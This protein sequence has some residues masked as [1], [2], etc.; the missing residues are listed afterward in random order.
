M[1]LENLRYLNI[2]L[3]SEDIKKLSCNKFKSI[4]KQKIEE[5]AMNYLSNKRK[6]KTKDID[7]KHFKPKQYLMSNNLSVTEVQNLYKLRNHMIDVKGNFHSGNTD[8]MWC[9]TCNLFTETQ[10]HLVYCPP[11]R[12]KLR[13][14]V[15]FDLMDHSMV[16]QSL[17][18]QEFYAKNYTIIL[19]ARE[20]VLSL[21]NG[22]Q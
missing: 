4:L 16:F 21:I 20:D 19:N 2:K 12:E 10:Q 14:L 9:R 7:I 6:E 13:G 17:K 11:I 8:N 22:D 3:S 15:E 1:C 5:T 18:K